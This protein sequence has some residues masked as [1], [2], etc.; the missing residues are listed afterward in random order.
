MTDDHA[1]AL[2]ARAVWFLRNVE[3]MSYTEIMQ[4]TE[5]DFEQ[6]SDLE[7]LGSHIRIMDKFRVQNC[8]RELQE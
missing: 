5:L 8:G 6:I 2:K 3:M 1:E 4:L 7:A